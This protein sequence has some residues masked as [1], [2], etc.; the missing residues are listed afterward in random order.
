MGIFC[1][2][3]PV[4]STLIKQTDVLKSIEMKFLKN[5]F[6]LFYVIFGNKKKAK[7]ITKK[8]LTNTFVENYI[9]FGQAGEVLADPG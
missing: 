6:M 4:Q 2:R 7:I 8:L 1:T 3:N 5:F 9:G